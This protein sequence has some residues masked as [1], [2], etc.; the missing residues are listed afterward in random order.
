MSHIA[1]KDHS[2]DADNAP[3]QEREVAAEAKLS[4]PSTDEEKTAGEEQREEA[5]EEVQRHEEEQTHQEVKP[6]E[7]EAVKQTEEHN[8]LPEAPAAEQGVPVHQGQ[9]EIWTQTHGLL[10]AACWSLTTD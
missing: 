8:E 9:P 10:G 1:P 6:E 2:N 5:H 4:N 7:K 3:H